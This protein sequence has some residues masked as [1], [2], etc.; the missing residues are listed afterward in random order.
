VSELRNIK[1]RCSCG[2]FRDGGAAAGPCTCLGGQTDSVGKTRLHKIWRGMND[3][4]ANPKSPDYQNYGGRGIAVCPE[5]SAFRRFRDDMG[6]PPSLAHTLE[7]IDGSKNYAPGNCR[8]AT[9]KEQN[10]NKRN[11]VLLTHAGKTMCVGEW[12]EHL[13]IRPGTIQRRMDY[14]W[15]VERCLTE[16]VAPWSRP[17]RA[18]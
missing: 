13:G 5:W 8:W 12:G 7:R 15:S 9:R 3:R 2:R 16:P 17:R 11:N 14:G 10:R 1:G 6:E 18:S 4:C